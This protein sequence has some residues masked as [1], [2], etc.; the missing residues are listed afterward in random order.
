[1]ST[2]FIMWLVIFGAL[3]IASFWMGSIYLSEWK[4][5]YKSLVKATVKFGNSKEV[6]DYEAS[7]I[8]SHKVGA[9]INLLVWIV[10][11][12]FTFLSLGGVF[13]VLATKL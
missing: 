6:P 12:F 1:M 13:W 10:S 8:A 9:K 11:F 4:N 3:L 7:E 2:A 5:E